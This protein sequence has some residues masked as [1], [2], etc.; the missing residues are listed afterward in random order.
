MGAERWL[1][2]D[3]VGARVLQVLAMICVVGM[4]SI[5]GLY[6]MY[7]AVLHT[8]IQILMARH[9]RIAKKWGHKVQRFAHMFHVFRP[10]FMVR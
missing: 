1:A 7:E 2:A 5:L 8:M 4:L 3:C 9:S 10:S 6:V